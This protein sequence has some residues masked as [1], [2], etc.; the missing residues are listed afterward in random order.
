MNPVLLAIDIGTTSAKVCLFSPT[1]GLI[2]K[3]VQEY[4]LQ[5]SENRVEAAAEVYLDAIRS[6]M[7]AVD[8][9]GVPIMAVGLTTQGETLTV[10]DGE[11]RPR[12]PFL[13][14]LDQRAN[15]EAEELSRLFPNETYYRETELPGLTGASPLAKALW[16]RRHEPQLFTGR[17]KLLL[18]E[19]CLLRLITGRFVTEKTMQ[20]STG[21]F[22]LRSDGWWQLALDAAGIEA[23]ALPE[24]LESGVYAG[25]STVAAEKCLGL[26]AGI[27]VFTGAMDQVS[28]SYAMRC[29]MPGASTETTGTALV[30]GAVLKRLNGL[31]RKRASRTTV[32]RHVEDGEYMLLPIGNTG[33][34][35]LTWFR[36]RFCPGMAYKTLDSLV[37][38]VPPGADGLL[39][40]PFLDGVVDPD[41]CP[42]ARAVFFGGTLSMSREHFAR[43]VMEGVA[44][45]LADMLGIMDVWGV[46][47]GPVCS[48]GGGARSPVWQRIKADVCNREFFTLPCEEAAAM[49]AALLAGRGAGVVGAVLPE[50]RVAARYLPSPR[51]RAL[52]QAA[53]EKYQQLYRSVRPLFEGGSNHG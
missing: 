43:A 50:P 35:C 47:P 1:L 29:L 34:M 2:R 9:S 5:T 12:R 39:F 46:P 30:A 4:H 13:V 10:T 26:P 32:Y 15:K 8:A 37:K 51:H 27:P 20:T 24:L 3:S 28:A 38:S 45:L 16:L 52:Y 48:L 25:H 40:L 7:R 21:W 36:D 22:S 19:D 53:H 23:D 41:L 14:W 18:L 6:G 17:H 11:G 33:G 42:G 31:E 49:G 44:H